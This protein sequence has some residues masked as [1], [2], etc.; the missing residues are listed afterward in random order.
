MIFRNFLSLVRN[1]TDLELLDVLIL[2]GP[3]PIQAFQYECLRGARKQ[4]EAGESEN[5]RGCS[6]QI[7][8]LE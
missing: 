7:C 4:R 2:A 3:V 6:P 8:S 5:L 1:T